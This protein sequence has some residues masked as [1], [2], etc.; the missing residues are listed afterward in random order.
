MTTNK[1]LDGVAL[2][3]SLDLEQQSRDLMAQAVEWLAANAPS[4]E[5]AAG[6]GYFEP[7]TDTQTREQVAMARRW[8]R[9]KADA[10]WSGLDLP[11]SLGGRGR[12][13]LDADLFALAEAAHNLPLEVF[14]ITRGMVV[15][16]LAQHAHDG[17][18]Q[19]LIPAALRGE[20]LFCQLFSEPACG[21]DIAA[22]TTSAVPVSDGWRIRGQK[23]WTSRAQHADYGLLLARTEADAPRRERLTMFCVP[24]TAAQVEVRPIRQLPGS[25]NFCEVFFDNLEV[26]DV[27]RVGDVGAGFAVALDTLGFE[28]AA[29]AGKGIPWGPLLGLRA[30]DPATDAETTIARAELEELR[31]AVLCARVRQ[32]Q[33]L[34]PGAHRGPTGAVVKLLTAHAA[35]ISSQLVLDAEGPD[36]ALTNPMLDYA[37]GTFGAR[38]GGGTEDI[39]RNTIAERLLGLPRD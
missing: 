38:T 27:A 2:A 36:A 5:V 8:E 19:R 23:V 13:A 26:L 29:L 6:L 10:G 18:A 39:L 1:H 32:T 31:L 9:A 37:L 16:T 14:A 17:L 7:Q 22:V 35:E 28:R 24:M 11:E 34:A 4:Y 20:T 25:A 12:T 3:A 33:A 30:V 21:S 15:P